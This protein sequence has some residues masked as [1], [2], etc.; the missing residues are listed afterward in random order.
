MKTNFGAM[1]SENYNLGKDFF[2]KIWG[3][4]KI[5]LHSECVIEACL[6][7]SINTDLNKEIFIVAGWLHDIGRKID[8]DSHHFLGINF[9]DDFLKENPSLLFFREEIADC[10]LNHRSD[11][12]PKT[13]YG[14]IFKCADKVALHNIKWL[15][16]NC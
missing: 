3:D 12:K 6:N 9:L 1:E 13:V 4:E 15:K 7:F 5:K 8:K 11:G 10:I 14:M 16:Y 2:E